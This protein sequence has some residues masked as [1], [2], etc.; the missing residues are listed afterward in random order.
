MISLI[1][2]CMPECTPEYTETVHAGVHLGGG[3]LGDPIRRK[4]ALTGNES[5]FKAQFLM[6]VSTQGECT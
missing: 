1:Y 2:E 3:V 4:C 6:I 5:Y